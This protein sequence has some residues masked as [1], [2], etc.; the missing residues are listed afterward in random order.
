MFNECQLRFRFRYIDKIPE[1]KVAESPALKFGSIIHSCLELI[2]KRVQNSGKA[3]EKEAIKTYFH[4]ELT[5]YRDQYDAV[6]ELPFSPQDYDDRISLGDEMLDRY[7]EKYAPFDQSKVNGL[8]QMINFSLPNGSKFRGI[9]DRLD[10]NDGHATIVDYKTDKS[11]A[12]YSIFED[13]YQ[14]QLTSYAIWV[15]S[16]YPHLITSVTG[17]LIFL[18]LEQE[19]S[20]EITS[21]ML[22]KAIEKITDT[23]TRI[24]ETLFRY[25]MG[26]RDAF[27]PTEGY[28]CRRCAYQVMCPL[29][30]HKFQDDEVIISTEIGE[31]TIKKLVDKFYDLNTQKKELEDQLKGIKEFLEQYAQSHSDEERKKLYGN[32]AEVR[33]DH[34]KEYKAQSQKGD[35]LKQFLLEND[36]LDLLTLQVNTN[37]LTK[38]LKENPGEMKEFAD[39]IELQEK[40][41]V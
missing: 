35:E 16:N 18:R 22:D 33:V 38:Y 24:Q 15:K 13:T 26:E 8:E 3:P 39:M 34:K 23:I 25:N 9:I 37:K 41:T 28:Q 40:V 27:V 5:R 11:I 31:T 10:L 32:E 6:S 2:H 19:I 20:R 36:F 21:E 29:W 14:Q 4:E 17:K 12:P 7:Y 1:P 30:K